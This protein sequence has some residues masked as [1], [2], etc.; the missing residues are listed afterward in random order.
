MPRQNNGGTFGFP[1][2]TRRQ[3][4]HKK[5][6]GSSMDSWRNTRLLKHQYGALCVQRAKFTICCT[7]SCMKSIRES[8]KR[9]QQQGA[10]GKFVPKDTGVLC[11]R[12]LDKYNAQLA[13]IRMRNQQQ[14]QDAQTNWIK[15][16]LERLGECI[17]AWGQRRREWATPRS[18][19]FQGIYGLYFTVIQQG[20]LRSGK[21]STGIK[22]EFGCI[23][24]CMT[25]RST[26]RYSASA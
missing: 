8:A 3:Q 16:L 25:S 22:Q 12:A 5:F 11:Q 14:A 18:V 17:A 13:L 20:I 6:Q 23:Y 4:T 7:V 10:E 9:H 15:E 19:L 21:S 2:G 1:L 26:R 24:L